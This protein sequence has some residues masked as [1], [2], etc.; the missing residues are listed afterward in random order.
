[1]NEILHTA[2]QIVLC[3]IGGVIG[4]TLA[5]IDLAPPLPVSHRSFWTHSPAIPAALWWWLV[6]Q[7]TDERLLWLALGFLPGFALHLA[8]DMFPKR[9]RGSARISFANRHRVG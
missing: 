6:N 7:N 4:L 1:M 2:T 5:D 8:Y 9:W 3:G